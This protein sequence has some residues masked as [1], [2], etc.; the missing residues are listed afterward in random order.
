M[1]GGGWSPCK[2]DEAGEAK[3]E[4]RLEQVTQG[5]VRRQRRRNGGVAE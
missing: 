2:E 5:K 4:G 1:N 3:V